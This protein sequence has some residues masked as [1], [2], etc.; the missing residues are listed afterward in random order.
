M[1]Q[2]E[3]DDKRMRELFIAS[4]TCSPEVLDDSKSGKVKF[5]RQ[6][7]YPLQF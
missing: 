7:N 1:L 4:R 6:I 2:P 5:A 3:P